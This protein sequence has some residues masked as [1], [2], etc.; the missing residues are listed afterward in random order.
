MTRS[1]FAAFIITFNRTDIL[2]STIRQICTQSVTP[3]KILIVNN[4]EKL[5]LNELP[6]LGDV[7]LEE[8]TMGFNSGPAG[9]AHYAMGRLERLGFKWIQWIDDDDP[10][11]ISN[12]NERL[13]RHLQEINDPK[14]GVIA[15]VG[16]Y[17]NTRNGRAIRVRN[18]Q[19]HN[20][21]Y[22]TVQTVGRNQCML[23]N[24]TVIR[25]GCL[26]TA[27]LFFGFEETNFCLKVVEAGF[28]I[29]VPADLFSEYRT[30]AKRWDLSKKDAT[31]FNIPPWRN[32]YSTR[33]LI[34]MFLYEFKKPGVV[35]RIIAGACLKALYSFV[36]R[37]PSWGVQ[38]LYF[39]FLG[40]NDGFRRK[41]GL[42][43]KPVS[44]H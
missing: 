21:R 29:I 30:L 3:A 25:S 38:E 35:S 18:E 39:T 19:I 33:N 24:S 15:P 13:F 2:Y 34:Y 5:N 44:K 23:I 11:K 7:E 4:G 16:S 27:S 12:L 41:L 17:F 31:K 42:T 28:S 37:G 43:V 32:Y 9:A 20:N 10:P 40:I 22:L 36:K 6:E 8:H 26:P 14:V 1:D